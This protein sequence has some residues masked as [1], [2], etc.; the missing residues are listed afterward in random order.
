MDDFGIL[1][2]SSVPDVDPDAW[3]APGAVLV[4][5]S[6]SSAAQASGTAASSAPT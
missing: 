1:R 4:G 3:V 2:R 6:P 5:G